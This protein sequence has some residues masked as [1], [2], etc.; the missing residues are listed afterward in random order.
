MKS[1]YSFLDNKTGVLTPPTVMQSDAE[2][3]RSLYQLFL[4]GNQQIPLIQFADDFTLFRLAD[5]DDEKGVSPLK[6]WDNIGNV[7]A[8]LASF[9][10]SL[11]SRD[12]DKVSTES[13]AETLTPEK[14]NG[15]T[16][17]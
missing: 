13:P 12:T 5:W 17:V 1:L 9:R 15:S 3:V 2:A 7:G 4:N 10:L 8:L 16:E 11:R 14:S 6:A